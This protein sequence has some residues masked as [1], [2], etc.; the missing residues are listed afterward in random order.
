MADVSIICHG[1]GT[2]GSVGRV[3]ANLTCPGC[4]KGDDLD[5]W[6]PKVAS[7]QGHGTGWEETRPN[8]LADWDEYEGPKP[9]PNPLVDQHLVG[10]PEAYNDG[11][12]SRGNPGYIPGGGYSV[13]NPGNHV[14]PTTGIPPI[15][16]YDEHQGPE[17]GGARWQGR[18]A[19]VPLH[20]KLPDGTE[21]E[22]VGRVVQ[23]G[24]PSSNPLG[25]PEDYLAGSYSNPGS[26]GYTTPKK[27]AHADNVV[28]KIDAQCPSC[29]HN[30][31]AL[32]RDAKDDGW[33][34]CPK[35]GPLANLDKHPEV[36]PHSPPFGF[37]PD[38][39][40]KSKKKSLTSSLNLLPIKSTGQIIKMVDA[41]R[42]KNS[43]LTNGE[44]L[45]LA[46]QALLKWGNN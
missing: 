9:G 27:P 29:G 38:R 32:T 45:T 12:W 20:V 1:C 30:Q 11:N 39:S 16:Q 28:L 46:R 22:G 5:L 23:A 13:G 15:E 2:T 37:T 19:S 3:T 14:G 26:P 42:E 8:V 35:C 4:G 43:G 7:P 31:T 21:W 10:D 18:H 25:T 40:M 41:I 33:W 17:T 44:V 36:N 24:R 6:E 34:G